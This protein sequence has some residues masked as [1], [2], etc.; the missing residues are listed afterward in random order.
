MYQVGQPDAL[1]GSQ[2]QTFLKSL[3]RLKSCVE[4][5]GGIINSVFKSFQKSQTCVKQFAKGLLKVFLKMT[6]GFS[7]FKHV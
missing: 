3:Q 2:I 6:V 5:A 1:W 4:S 7:M